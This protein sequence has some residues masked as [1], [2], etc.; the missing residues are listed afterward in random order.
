MSD[1]LVLGIDVGGTRLRAGLVPADGP[2]DRPTG[3]LDEAVPSDLDGFLGRLRM[4][5]TASAASGRRIA[6]I[7]L[8]VP[9]IAEGPRAGW[10]PK[11]PW[12]D[13]VD[14][15]RE[16]GLPVTVANDAQLALLA[17]ATHGA[18][19][20][21][22]DVVLI[23]VGTG[24]GSAVMAGGR[25]VT[26]G[27]GAACSA[28]WI[29]LDASDAGD[30]RDG[31]LE[32]HAAGPT[33]DRLAREC[34]LADGPALV[35]AAAGGDAGA[36]EAVAAPARVLGLAIAAAVALLDPEL[37]LL[38]GGLADGLATLRPTLDDVLARQ[39]PPHLR[40]ITI[41]AG[42]F[43]SGAGLVGA[44]IAGQRGSRWTEV[45]P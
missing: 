3:I 13:G 33:Y 26:G 31:W 44:A 35:A 4:L 36:A 22:G 45:R 41:D 11:L 37:V 10:V 14:L 18:A 28:G 34:G 8:A 7:G 29:A 20:A 30:D 15:D 32:R 6:G 16:L 21:R 27:H 24:I 25:I 2:A 19:R 38:A 23:A 9:G 42:R 17:E 43:G 12:L 40:G 39:L 1:D 5:L